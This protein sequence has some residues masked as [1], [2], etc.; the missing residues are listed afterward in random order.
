MHFKFDFE[1]VNVFWSSDQLYI[2]QVTEMKKEKTALVIPNAVQV[3]HIEIV[4]MP[5]FV[6]CDKNLILMRGLTKLKILVQTIW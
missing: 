5:I 1:F 4:S 3:R 2:V 6:I